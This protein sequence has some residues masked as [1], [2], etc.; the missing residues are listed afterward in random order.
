LLLPLREDLPLVVSLGAMTRDADAFGLD[1]SLFWG[2]RSY[3]FHGAYNLSG[4]LILGLQR[5]FGS[6][7][8]S[9]VSLGVQVDA[10]VFAI[11]V[12]LLRGALK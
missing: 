3:N 11:P 10:F 8:D 2:I 6:H 5:T 7:S 1:G 9:L 12:L 4:G